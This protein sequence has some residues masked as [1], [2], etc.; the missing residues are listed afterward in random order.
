[1][2]FEIAT[3]YDTWNATGLANLV[4]GKVPLN[5]AS[6]Y[7]LAFGEFVVAESGGYMLQLNMPYAAEVQKQ[8]RTRAP[9]AAIYAGTGD[10]GVAAAV[11]DNR[12]NNNRSE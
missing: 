2:G 11:E 10:A 1:M 4:Q 7:N 6:R 5:V 3:W 12:N 8:I 9:R